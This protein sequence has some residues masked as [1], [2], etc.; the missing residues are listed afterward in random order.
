MAINFKLLMIVLLLWVHVTCHVIFYIQSICAR[1][2]QALGDV[3]AIFGALKRRTFFRIS[4]C[5][6]FCCLY[7]LCFG[8][9]Y[10]MLLTLCLNA[11]YLDY[12]HDMIVSVFIIVFDKCI[13]CLDNLY[14]FN[15]F[16]SNF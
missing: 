12:L 6:L 4:V 1:F 7:S 16:F 8:V 2:R 14:C 3:A 5:N 11:W 13:F 10:V 9:K 15:M